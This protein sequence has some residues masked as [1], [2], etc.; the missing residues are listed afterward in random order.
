MSSK[1]EKQLE[2]YELPTT[3]DGICSLIRH[4]LDGGH[5]SRL[6]MDNDDAYVR[7][8]RWVERNDLGEPDINWDGA[9]R[10]VEMMEYSSERA[11]PFQV[12]VDMMLLATDRGL[13]CTTWALGMGGSALLKDWLSLKSRNMPVGIPAYLL[14]LPIRELKSLP[15]ETLILCCSKFPNADPSEVSFAIKTTIDVRGLNE[16]DNDSSDR[17]GHHS[18]EH[19]SAAHQLALSPRGLRTVAWKAASDDD[20]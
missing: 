1:S 14:G 3:I 4:I 20:R 10:N 6:E 19:A 13:K 9:L 17:S 15:S 16:P 18:E 12:L 5:V 8:W 11:S 7:A 2:K